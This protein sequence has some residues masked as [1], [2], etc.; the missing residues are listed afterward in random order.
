MNGGS[1]LVV[2]LAYSFKEDNIE[3]SDFTNH[4]MEEHELVKIHILYISK[5]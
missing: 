5:S 3:I 4:R 2:F 1:A